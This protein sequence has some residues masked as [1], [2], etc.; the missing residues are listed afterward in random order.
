LNPVLAI[1]F[2]LQLVLDVVIIALLFLRCRGNTQKEDDGRKEEIEK[3]IELYQSVIEEA[4]GAVVN[5]KIAIE[6]LIRLKKET[7]KAGDTARK[8]LEESASR[9]EEKVIAR[10]EQMETIYSQLMQ[11]EEVERFKALLIHNMIEQGRSSQEIAQ[12]LGLPFGEV[13][14]IARMRQRSSNV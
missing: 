3:E 11:H 7:Q 6:N 12:E 14:L 9:A 10:I 1:L 4:K 5:A 8:R 13:E 2:A